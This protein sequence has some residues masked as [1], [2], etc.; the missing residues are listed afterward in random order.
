MNFVTK[1]AVSA[2]VTVVAVFGVVAPSSAATSS[3]Q[4]V[5]ATSA[6]SMDAPA[7]VSR[8][9]AGNIAR[10]ASCIAGIESS[11]YTQYNWFRGA[12]DYYAS[13]KNCSNTNQRIQFI[14]QG[15]LVY[16]ECTTIK[17]GKTYTISSPSSAF[18][19]IR[20]C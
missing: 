5:E 14:K 8:P 13:A 4:V 16:N 7:S 1:L 2:A 9:S 12:V 19:G 20:H 3:P 18:S 15:G 17:P 6:V 10:A 11:Y